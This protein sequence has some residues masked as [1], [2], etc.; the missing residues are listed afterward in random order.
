MMGR[1]RDI[2]NSAVAAVLTLTATSVA[3]QDSGRLTSLL[4]ELAQP[5][6][7]G[8]R[9]VERQVV[10]EWSKSGSAAMDLLLQRGREAMAEG[11]MPAAIDHLTAL[12]DHAPDFAEGW[13]ARATALFRAGQMGPAMQDLSRVLAL[14]PSHFGALAG[15]GTILAETGNTKAALA[16]YKAAL[17]IH[18]HL[19]KVREA[20]ERLER[21]L[22]GQQI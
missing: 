6:N 12:T 11:D 4:A 8:W 1:V 19:E 5:E 10:T 14:N 16:A 3:A 18:P 17:A 7:A 9:R 2:L 22:S 21:D 15:V 20:A 13:N